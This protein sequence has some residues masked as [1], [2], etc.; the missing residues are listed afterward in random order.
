VALTHRSASRPL[1]P[2]LLPVLLAVL[3][4]LLE[5]LVPTP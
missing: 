2:V 5:L 4:A 3:L 1:L